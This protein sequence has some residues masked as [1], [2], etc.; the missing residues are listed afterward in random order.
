MRKQK[1]KKI[2]KK[3]IWVKIMNKNRL[4][5]GAFSTTFSRIRGES[6]CYFCQRKQDI[7]ELR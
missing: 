1:K 4:E 6:T 5:F 7:F 3:G 2:E